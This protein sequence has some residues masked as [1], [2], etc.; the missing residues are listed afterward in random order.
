MTGEKKPQRPRE[1][2]PPVPGQ[3]LH[4]GTGNVPSLGITGS[5]IGLVQTVETVPS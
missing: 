4:G 2:G 5:H 1:K 3:M